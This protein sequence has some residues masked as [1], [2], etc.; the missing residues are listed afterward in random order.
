M[1]GLNP[2]YPPGIPQVMVLKYRPELTH[3]IW[4]D[5]WHRFRTLHGVEKGLRREIK[6]GR[7]VGYRFITINEEHIGLPPNKEKGQSK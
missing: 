3:S 6:A 5:Y 2:Q 1:K 4:V 7:I